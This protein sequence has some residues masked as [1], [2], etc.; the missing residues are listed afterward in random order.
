MA[1]RPRRARTAADPDGA[2][3]VFCLTRGEASKMGPER[4]LA[5]GGLFRPQGG[6]GSSIGTDREGKGVRVSSRA[7]PGAAPG[8]ERCDRAGG[9]QARLD[10]AVSYDQIR[11]AVAAAAPDFLK[12]IRLFDVYTGNTVDSGRKS[13]ALGLIL[14]ASSHTLTDEE[15]DSVMGRVLSHLRAELGAQLRE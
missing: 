12:D 13:I 15:V 1:T 4:G 6:P 2:A 8:A 5:P 9:H 11:A 14:Q 10:E 7:A 3:A